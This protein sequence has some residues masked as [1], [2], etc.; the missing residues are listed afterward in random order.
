MKQVTLLLAVAMIVV[1]CGGGTGGTASGLPGAGATPKDTLK[2]M[3]ASIQSGDSARFVDCFKANDDAKRV[4]VELVSFAK[5]SLDFGKKIEATYGKEAAAKFNQGDTDFTTLVDN[6]EKAEVK[7][8]GDKAVLT[9]PDNDKPM[10][11]VK[12]G[13][14]WRLEEKGMSDMKPEQADMALKMFGPMKTAMENAMSKIG[15]EGETPETIKAA[16]DA[17]M[18]KAAMEM[19][20]EVM[21][22][23]PKPE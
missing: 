1:G 21:K 23:M 8:D 9:I 7:I 3:V 17:E 12:D 18:K 4:L 5:T 6:A 11:M 19:M 16:M 14:V 10:T 2:S 13:A 20:K 22:N 15:A